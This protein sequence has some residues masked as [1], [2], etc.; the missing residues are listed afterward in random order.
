MNNWCIT[1]VFDPADERF[2]GR[3]GPRNATLTSVEAIRNHPD[4]KK[5]RLVCDDYPEEGNIMAEGWFVGEDEF[6]PLDNFGEGNWG[7]TMIFYWT[8][9]K[10]GGWQQL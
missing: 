10:G 9:G 6:A 7:C 4:A 2:I 5:F 1:K 3:I 8:P